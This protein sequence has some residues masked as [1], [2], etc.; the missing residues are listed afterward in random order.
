MLRLEGID[1]RLG[2][3]QLQ[4]DLSLEPGQRLA[5]M[6]ESG[7]GKST[8]LSLISGFQRPDAG[9]VLIGGRDVTRSAVA[10][11]PL[12]ILFQD[13]NLFPHLS[14]FDNVALGIEP[15]LKLGGQDQARV[16]EALNRVGLDG[17]GARKPAALSGGQQSRVALARMLLRDQP[18]ALLDEPFAALDPGLRREM[19]SLLQE[20]C[21]ATGLTLVM[22]SHDLRDTERLCDR[23]LMLEAGRIALDASMAE[24]LKD[25]P[26]VLHPWM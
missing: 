6:G 25:A 5:V 9:R 13:G 19:L 14:V 1:L 24:V 10:E 4:A 18:L 12:S 7:S 17:M 3:F 21:E 11:R 26:P 8:L 16:A 23:L 20:L 22:V 15:S 2:A